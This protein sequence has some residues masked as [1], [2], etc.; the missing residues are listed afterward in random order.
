MK[1]CAQ[2]ADDGFNPEVCSCEVKD[3]YR[4]GKNNKVNP[5]PTNAGGLQIRGVK[6]EVVVPLLRILDNKGS[7]VLRHL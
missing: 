7:G 3:R 6:G 2:Q 1:R 4:L 5:N